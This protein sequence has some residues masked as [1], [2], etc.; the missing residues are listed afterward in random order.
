MAEQHIGKLPP[1]YS[2]LMNPYTDVRVSKCPDCERPTHLRKFALMIHIDKWG[3]M[4]LGKTCRYCTPCEL[5]IVHRDEL[6]SELTIAFERRAPE[7]VGNE[8]FVF[9]TMDKKF[10][11]KGL[12]GGMPLD[13]A[14]E[15][16][17]DFKSVSELEVTGG[18]VL[19]RPEDEEGRR[20]G[21]RR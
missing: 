9:G 16:V 2:L 21:G 12:T 4:A 11:Q 6:E 19:E 15:H 8:Y 20:D 18:W 3:P 13:D 1:R 10:W 7:V 17:A 14:L 5:V